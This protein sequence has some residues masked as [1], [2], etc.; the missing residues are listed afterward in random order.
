[1]LGDGSCGYYSL[2]YGMHLDKHKRTEE[3]LD[4]PNSNFEF[5]KQLLS[6]AKNENVIEDLLDLNNINATYVGDEVKN[7]LPNETNAAYVKR[8]LLDAKK[9]VMRGWKPVEAE[10]GLQSFANSLASFHWKKQEKCNDF[11]ENEHVAVAAHMLKR[12][13]ALYNVGSARLGENNDLNETLEVAQSKP[14]QVVVYNGRGEKLSYSATDTQKGL[15]PNPLEITINL[16]TDGEH[17]QYIKPKSNYSM[18]E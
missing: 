5:R 18:L 3:L 2:L 11:L 14:S 9:C 1:M 4:G 12:Q 16:L 10:N 8:H 6:Y 17:F 15:V 7:H 13:I